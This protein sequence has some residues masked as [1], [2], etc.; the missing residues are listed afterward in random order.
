M[1]P[2]WEMFQYAYRICRHNTPTNSYN[3]EQLVLEA[4]FHSIQKN[5]NLD[6]PVH[7]GLVKTPTNFGVAQSEVRVSVA[8]VSLPSPSHTILEN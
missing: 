6:L 1:C 2:V 4:H 5:S 7:G 8:S 3:K